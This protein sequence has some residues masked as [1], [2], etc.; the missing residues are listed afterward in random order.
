MDNIRT[1]FIEGQKTDTK[2]ACERLMI[3]RK[4]LKDY[5]A[6]INATNTV[7]IAGE[8]KHLYEELE[9]T[10]KLICLQEQQL[11]MQGE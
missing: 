2:A 4:M 7:D 6:A 5:K 9:A 1:S 3:T 11:I 10:M 8:H